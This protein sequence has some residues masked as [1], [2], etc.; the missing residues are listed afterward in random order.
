M[1]TIQRIFFLVKQQV[2]HNFTFGMLLSELGLP[3]MILPSIN[4]L[5]WRGT[6]LDQFELFSREKLLFVIFV[7]F[8]VVTRYRFEPLYHNQRSYS[9]LSFFSARKEQGQNAHGALRIDIYETF[10]V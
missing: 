7:R 5:A 2:L 10:V 1:D 4:F 8:L 3:L 6:N 9:T